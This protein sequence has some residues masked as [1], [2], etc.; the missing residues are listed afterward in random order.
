M[1]IKLMA[2]QTFKA[3]VKAGDRPTGC[4]VFRFTSGEPIVDA[5]TR[6]ARFVFS[7]DTVDRAGDRIMQDGWDT[8]SFEANPVALFSH[9]STE[10]PIGRASN[11]SVRGNELIGDIE[12]ASADIYPFADTIYRLVQGG[13]LKA[14]SVGFIPTEYEYV[15]TKDRPCGL[16]F[17]QQTLLEISVCA[18]PCNPNALID[19]RAAGI[20]TEPLRQWA[21]KVLDTGESVVVPRKLLEATFR[22]AKTP[23]VI[24]QRFLNSSEAR[25]MT[26]KTGGDA[27]DW[28]CGAARD[29]PIDDADGWDGGAAEASIFEHAG[30]DDFDPAKARDGFLAYDA[31]K[32]KLRGSYKLPFAHVVGGVLKAVKGGIRAASSRLPNT[33]IPDGTKASV[34]EV[35]D[36]YEKKMGVGDDDP[37]KAMGDDGD[38]A[39][40]PTGYCGNDADEECLMKDPQQCAVHAKPPDKALHKAGRR[41]SSKN[42]DHLAKAAGHIKA[43]MDSNEPDDEDGET[44]PD[45]NDGAD[46]PPF[47]FTSVRE[48]AKKT[49][50]LT[51]AAQER[52]LTE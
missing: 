22:A 23:R 7:D 52:D 48:S 9:M 35:I 10:P 15:N 16:D 30:G 4:A 26:T 13:Y 3:A 40:V 36:A 14:V 19:A 31:S 32:P 28:K 46:D 29:L 18:L 39:I 27:A 2:P 44:D 43:I 38:T 11:V 5:N 20:D 42:M 8:D 25:I 12:F 49:L 21:S 37:N 24:R 17:I 47:E 6:T 41:I 34:K 45:P 50:A 51:R 33:D 1:P